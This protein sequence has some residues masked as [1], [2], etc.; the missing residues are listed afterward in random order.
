MLKTSRFSVVAALFLSHALMAIPLEAQEA[1]PVTY[2]LEAGVVYGEG[3]VTKEG[4]AVSRDLWMDVYHP[5]ETAATPRPAVILTFGGAFHRGSPRLTLQSGG[6]QDTSMGNYC[7]RFAARGYTCFAI[8]YRLTPEGPVPSGKGYQTDW[9][10]PDSLL[11]LLPQANHIRET[12]D[13]PPLDF[14]IPEQ[15]KTMVDGVIS[16]AEDLH[17]AVLHVRELADRYEIDPNRIALGGF[18]AGAVTSWNVAHGMG[19]PVSGVFLLSGT[20][21]GFDVS[22][23]VTASSNRPPILVFMGQYD[24]AGALSSVP[25]LIA[26]YQKVDVDYEFAWV[27]GFGHFY[28]AGAASLGSNAVSMSVEGRIAEFLERV[29]G[30]GS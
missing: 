4:K 15:E 12:M 16:A 11:P 21:A 30:K 1:A 18:S 3:L 28:P 7:R 10:K 9:I 25:Q 17:K 19:V 24:L 26:H 8:D 5:T 27:P 23:A 22:K 14:S 13:L 20:D 2:S 6:A 29:I